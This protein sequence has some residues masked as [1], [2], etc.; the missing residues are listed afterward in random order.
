[1]EAPIAELLSS[2]RIVEAGAVVPPGGTDVPAPDPPAVPSPS[3]SGPP[4]LTGLRVR[5]GRFPAARRGAPIVRR[6]GARVTYTL[7]RAARVVFT[8]QRRTGRRW[9]RVRGRFVHAGKLGA[10]AL[11]FSGRVGGKRLSA[12]RYR[13]AGTPEGGQPAQV[14]FAIR[15]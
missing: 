4:H 15:R 2:Q 11:R 5:P 1:M 7:D 3:E 9:T 10:N 6:G 12:G 14:K 13:L 8:V